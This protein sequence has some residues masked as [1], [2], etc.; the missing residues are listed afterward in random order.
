MLTLSQHRVYRF[1]RQFMEQHDYSPT[2]LE[3]AAG[4]GI[5]SRGVVHRYLKALELAGYI[6]LIPHKKR[7]IHLKLICDNEQLQTYYDIMGSQTHVHK[8]IS[9][10]TH[11]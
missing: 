5:Q 3:I 10:S 4:I 7:N 8:G 11:V 1:I 6:E 9:K 2:T